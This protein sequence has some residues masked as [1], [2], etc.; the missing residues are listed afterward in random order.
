M[1]F[2][3]VGDLYAQLVKLVCDLGVAVGFLPWWA[4]LYIGFKIFDK[5]RRKIGTGVLH[6]YEA[7]NRAFLLLYNCALFI[8][9]KQRAKKTSI[10]TDMKLTLERI[11]RDKAKEKFRD[12]DLQFPH[13][14]WIYL[15]LT[16][17][18]G[19][20]GKLCTLYRCRKFIRE[21]KYFFNNRKHYDER[22][23]RQILRHL[24]KKWG[25]AYNDFIFEYDYERYGL[26]YNNGLMIVDIFEALE[27]YAQLYKIYGQRTPL[28]VNNYSIREDLRWDDEGNFPIYD[29]D[30]FDRDPKDIK[31]YSQYSHIIPYNA[32][33]LGRLTDAD[34][35]CLV[36]VDS[37][38]NSGL[39]VNTNDTI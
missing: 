37:L 38:K 8:T 29:G 28:D 33:R 4:W 32:F 34:A 27:K 30:F 23:R 9:G 21:L 22:Q 5:T 18:A 26:T 24:K 31:Q 13:F 10:L 14:N 15:E 20:A 17:K 16:V 39:A 35:F 1:A 19:Q 11:F 3:S 7:C 36:G 6:F 2:F 12:R 25:Y